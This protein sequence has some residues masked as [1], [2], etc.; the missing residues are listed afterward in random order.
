METMTRCSESR[1]AELIDTYGKL[2]FSICYKI[3]GD[4]FTAEDIT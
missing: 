3:T 2:V 4:Y 1:L